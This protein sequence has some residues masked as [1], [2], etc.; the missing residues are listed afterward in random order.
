MRKNTNNNNTQIRKIHV[1]GNT[2]I[3]NNFMMEDYIK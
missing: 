2:K 3:I 1:K